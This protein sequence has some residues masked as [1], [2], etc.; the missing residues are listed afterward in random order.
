MRRLA[1]CSAAFAVALL[2]FSGCV[3]TPAGVTVTSRVPKDATESNTPW[4]VKRAWVFVEGVQ[5][6]ITPATIT[7]RRSFE[8]TNVS[9][10]VG[11]NFE[12]VRRYEIERTIT[13]SRRMLDFSF[14]G[15]LDG[16]YPTFTAQ[17]LSKDSKGNYI[18]P[19]YERAIQIVD[20]EYDL[21]IIV[22]Q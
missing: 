11:P 21:E 19:Y 14:R 17:E 12:Q 16:A 13:G 6:V 18:I 3:S 8:I 9:L 15:T 10:H 1:F 20:H 5:Q 22:R 4:Q 7:V 2:F